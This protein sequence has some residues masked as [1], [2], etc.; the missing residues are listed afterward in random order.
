[1][2]V[3]TRRS[4]ESVTL[5]DDIVVKILSVGKGQVRIGISAPPN[6][7]VLREEIYREMEAENRASVHGVKYLD[8]IGR[9]LKHWQGDQRESEHEKRTK[10][11][12]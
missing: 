11:E 4:G 10:T 7:R 1:M 2:L 6:V 9:M 12:E 3:L 5:G 8:Q